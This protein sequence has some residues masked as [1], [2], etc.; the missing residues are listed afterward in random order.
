MNR[1]VIL[2]RAENHHIERKQIE[3]L[4]EILDLPLEIGRFGYVLARLHKLLD[5]IAEMWPLELQKAKLLWVPPLVEKLRSVF[6]AGEG[7]AFPHEAIKVSNPLYS[8]MIEPYQSDDEQL[9]KNHNLLLAHVLLAQVRIMQDT[10]DKRSEFSPYSACLTIR[11]LADGKQREQGSDILLRTLRVDLR[12]VVFARRARLI[13]TKDLDRYSTP[14]IFE[15]R[16]YIASFLEGAYGLRNRREVGERSRSRSELGDSGDRNAH[17][18]D[19]TVHEQNPGDIPPRANKLG[20]HG[21]SDDDSERRR[22]EAL[23][24]DNCPEED[25]EEEALIFSSSFESNDDANDEQQ[26]REGKSHFDKEPE[27]YRGMAQAMRNQVIRENKNFCFGYERLMPFEL[28]EIDFYG[29]RRLVRI[30]TRESHNSKEQ[31]EAEDLALLLATFWLGKGRA[32]YLTIVDSINDRPGVDYALVRPSA[33]LPAIFRMRVEF[34]KYRRE[35]PS[36]AGDRDSTPYVLLPDYFDLADFLFELYDVQQKLHKFQ[37]HGRHGEESQQDAEGRIFLDPEDAYARL[38]KKLKEEI[39]PRS[40]RITLAKISAAFSGYVTSITG[41]DVVAAKFITG[42]DSRVSRVAMFYACR[43]QANINE[44]F[45]RC[46]SWIQQQIR[47]GVG[48]NDPPPK[49]YT[50]AG[51]RQQYIKARL[52]PT[53]QSVT[54]AVVEII[55]RINSLPVTDKQYHNLLTLYTVIF[56]GYATLIRGICDPIV[57]PRSISLLNNMTLVRD[58]TS[59]SGDKA[60]YVYIP[61]SLRNHL[62]F[63]AK[64]LGSSFL[65]KDPNRE[66]FFYKEG[67]GFEAVKPTTINAKL[68]EFLPFP[69]AVH[70]RFSFNELIEGGCDPE[71]VRICMGHSTIGDEPWSASSSFAFSRYRKILDSHIEPLLTKLGFQAFGQPQS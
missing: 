57:L 1:E 24:A 16:D 12:P 18:G 63:F 22:N 35:Q 68:R 4:W 42:F 66:L 55:K 41:N 70:R 59:D 65:I 21:E 7:S 13:E 28:A 49:E 50:K 53:V 5:L 23:D 47:K 9:R 15:W 46:V 36:Q 62:E 14:K 8:A 61:K 20:R 37:E 64:H 10:P 67:G 48:L 52:C 31:Q 71:V 54:K 44:V 56:F 33:A 32:P 40:Q 45:H 51:W 69:P 29:R 17:F 58:K 2:S 25:E 3:Q 27:S 38:A 6:N 39:D 30:L 11:Q 60:K 19:V 26:K 43:S 34:P